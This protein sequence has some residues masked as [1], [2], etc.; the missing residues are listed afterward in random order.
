MKKI[1]LALCTLAAAAGCMHTYPT[2]HHP[3]PGPG[4]EHIETHS[5]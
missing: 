3:T 1:L 5:R 2:L 4:Y